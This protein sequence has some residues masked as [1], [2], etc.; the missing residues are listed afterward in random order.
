MHAC[1]TNPETLR[2]SKTITIFFH[3]RYIDICFYIII[4]HHMKKIFS[5]A[6]LAPV[7]LPVAIHAPCASRTHYH[8]SVQDASEQATDTLCIDLSDIVSDD[9]HPLRVKQ[10]GRDF[11]ALLGKNMA[12]SILS[13]YNPDIVRALREKG[14]YIEGESMGRISYDS[15]AD[16]LLYVPAVYP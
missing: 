8:A 11:N 13:R 5:A 15:I 1:N 10:V 7:F 16:E 9:R 4:I 6:L 14:L 3:T 2:E 12:D